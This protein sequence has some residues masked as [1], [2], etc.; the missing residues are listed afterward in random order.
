[1]SILAEAITHL[2][3]DPG[4]T[5]AEGGLPGLAVLKKVVSSINLFAIIATVGALAVAGVVW[6]WGHHTGSHGAE[7][8]GKQGV[9]AAGGVALLL[10]AANG[11]VSFFSTLGTQV[12]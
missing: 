11:L 10:G 9:L 12:K 8:K 2:A 4:V 5:P 7:A 3:Y 6:A 1:M